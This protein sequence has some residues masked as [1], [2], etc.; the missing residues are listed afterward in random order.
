MNITKLSGLSPRL[1]P[2]HPKFCGILG[3]NGP[4]LNDVNFLATILGAFVY[5]D[6]ETRK[7]IKKTTKIY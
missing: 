3:S 5:V 1:H 6:D 2:L 7:N 4:N